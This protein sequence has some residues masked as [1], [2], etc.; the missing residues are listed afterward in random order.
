MAKTVTLT[1]TKNAIGTKLVGGEFTFTLY[2]DLDAKVDEAS[3]DSQGIVTFDLDF[4]DEGVYTYT[5]EETD[6]PLGWIKDGKIYPVEIEI[7]DSPTGLI[8]SVSYPDGH[9]GFVN[10]LEA[11]PCSLIVF[12]ELSFD[13]AGTYEYVLKEITPSGGGWLTDDAEYPVIVTVADDGYGNLIA[14]LDYPEGYP[15]FT[16]TYVLRPVKVVISAVKLAVGADLPCGMFEFGLF[17]SDNNLV[18]T[19]F[20]GVEPEEDN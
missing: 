9:P 1:L 20:N 18:A 10:K 2:D 11:D 19:A 8:A 4:D 3:N 13:E 17:D 15:E 12:P 5:I 16:N 6:T 14:T 7:V